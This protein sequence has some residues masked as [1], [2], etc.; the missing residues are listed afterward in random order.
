MNNISDNITPMNDTIYCEQLRQRYNAGERF[1]M[2]CFWDET[3]PANGSVSSACLS[4]WFGAPI[5][6]DGIRYP[7][8]EHFMMAAKALLFGDQQRFEQII[9]APSPGLAKV[10][11]R[12]VQGFDEETWYG[13]RFAI[14]CQ[15]NQAKFSQHPNLR[16]F[17][18]ETENHVLVQASPID[19]IWGVGLP[20]SNTNIN[21]PNAWRG[22]NLLGFA[23]M[24]VRESLREEHSPEHRA[25][26]DYPRVDV[27]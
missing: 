20:Q 27:Q 2:L 18:L 6:L 22:L 9:T 10:F 11:G 26:S 5:E 12:K 4:Q 21:N 7:T 24:K 13:Q 15:A 8:N 25:F 1:R 16:Q 17:L 23:L 14:V 19:R 3:A